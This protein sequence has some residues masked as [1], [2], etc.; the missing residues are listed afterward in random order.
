[1]KTALLVV[2]PAYGRV[3]PSADA[4][5]DAFLLDGRDFSPAARGGPYMSV[6]DFIGG[7]YSAPEAHQ[8]LEHFTGVILTQI[9]SPKLQV[10][11]T[12]EEM[13]WPPN[14]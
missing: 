11:V 1:M 2:Y 13:Q 3:Y 9:K 7:E 8:A 4:M 6:R 10:I 12:R 5:R 14:I